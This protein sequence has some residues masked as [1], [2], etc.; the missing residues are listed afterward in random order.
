MKSPSQGKRQITQ[1]TDQ[2]SG[3]LNEDVLL[4]EKNLFGVFDGASSLVP[5]F[6]ADGKTGGKLAADIAYQIFQQNPI[7]LSQA[8]KEAN[9]A[10][11]AAELKAGIDV[12]HKEGLWGTTVSVVRLQ[13]SRAEYIKIGNSPILVINADGNCQLM[14]EDD[15]HD[16]ETL[17][18]WQKLA[19]KKIADPWKSMEEQNRKVR[20]KVN[21]TYGVLNG[22]KRA[23][24]FIQSGSMP[25]EG[26]RAIIIL[27]DGFLI[28]KEDPHQEERWESF[29]QLYL[30]G[31]LPLLLNEIRRLETIDLDAWKYPRLKRHDDASAMAIEFNMLE[32]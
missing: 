20:R 1:I 8:I 19:L 7:N 17:L 26:V 14:G 28:P 23:E 30:S 22:E 31:G 25:L 32:V 21:E 2:G 4:Q 18:L 5:Y 9:E 3:A 16:L 10:I 6:N 12:D 15:K 29:K 11:H 13:D 24:Y 27:S